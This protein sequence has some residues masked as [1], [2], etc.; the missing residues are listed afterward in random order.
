MFCTHIYYNGQCCCR[1]VTNN[2]QPTSNICLTHSTLVLT[3]NSTCTTITTSFLF[4]HHNNPRENC[5]NCLYFEEG[6]RT[7]Q[8]CVVEL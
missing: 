4:A 8:L 2:Q 6:Q 7:Y 3:A 1:K 5:M